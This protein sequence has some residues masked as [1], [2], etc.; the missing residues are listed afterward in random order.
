M[1]TLRSC[2]ILL[3]GESQGK[4]NLPGRSDRLSN[5]AGGG[6]G[7]ARLPREDDGGSPEIPIEIGMVGKIEKFRPKL[8]PPFGI[9]EKVSLEGNVHVEHAR[10]RD[11]VASHIPQGSCRGNAIHRRIKIL[12][13]PAEN[14]V[15][16]S[17]GKQV[18]PTSRKQVT[19]GAHTDLRTERDAG[20]KR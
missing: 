11:R 9:Q 6:I 5:A 17:A 19:G 2:I 10:R 12:V 4:L 1:T 3:K 18:R 16:A 20:A 13:R 15:I 14:G 7:T 8:K